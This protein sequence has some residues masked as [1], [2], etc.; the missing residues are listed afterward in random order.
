MITPK[1]WMS[2]P[3]LVAGIMSG[4]SLD[5]IDVAIAEFTSSSAN[6]VNDISF[7]S[8]KEFYLQ[9]ERDEFLFLKS[10]IETPKEISVVADAHFYLMKLYDK[11]LRKA[12]VEHSISIDE[13]DAIGIHGQT[14]WHHPSE[15]EIP[16]I[17][18]AYVS[19]TLQLGSVS[20]LSAIAES[21]VVGDFRSADVACGG[22]GAP[23]VPVFD[24]DFLRDKSHHSVA[25]NIGGMSNITLLPPSKSKDVIRAFDTGP[26]NVWIDEVCLRYYGKKYDTNGAFARSGV[27]ISPLLEELQQI[28]FITQEPPKS[29]GR[30]L[31]SK[32]ALETLLYKYMRIARPPEDFLRTLTEFT[33]WSIAENIRLYAPKTKKVLVSGGGAKNTFLMELLAKELP[34]SRVQNVESKGISSDAKEALCFAYLAY[35]TLAGLPSNIPSVTGANREVILGVVADGRRLP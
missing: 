19:T 9:F 4:T 14:V 22:Q 6:K 16:G 11:A 5:G 18:G 29:T 34:N 17:Q 28:P 20:A 8:C 1:Q 33:A 2:K 10:I 24:R 23:L 7:R 21:I 35:R 12:C 31:F 26:G 3:R 27:V 32:L 13:I 30:E 25:V 15:H